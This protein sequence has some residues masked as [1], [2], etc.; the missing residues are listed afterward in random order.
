[1]DVTPKREFWLI[2]TMAA[3]GT[4][5]N[6]AAGSKGQLA[7]NLAGIALIV[8]LV[9]VGVAY[10]IDQTARNAQRPLP[11]L[12]DAD[13]ITQ[14]VAGRELHIPTAW[15]RFGESI[16]PGFVSQ[17]DLVFALPLIAGQQPTLVEVTLISRG[18]ARASSALLD[19]VYLHQF[20]ENSVGGIPGLVGKPLLAIDGYA[21]ETV[22]YDPLS[23]APFVAKCAAA[24]DP[25]RSDRCLRTIHLPN[26]LAAILSFDAEALVAWRQFD[27]ELAQWLGKIGALDT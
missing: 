9:A 25:S 21:D 16:T 10:L 7:Y 18:G 15:F 12:L 26:G 17:V 13:P 22:W 6:A 2:S 8:L 20:A 1:M 23:P 27:A 19:A 24:P 14:T 3:S 4:D 11:S 5:E